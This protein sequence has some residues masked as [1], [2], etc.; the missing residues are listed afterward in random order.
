MIDYKQANPDHTLD[1]FNKAL[2]E[3]DPDTRRVCLRRLSESRY[4]T[5]S[6]CSLR[7]Q[8][9]FCSRRL[10]MLEAKNS[11]RPKQG[12]IQLP[13]AQPPRLFNENYEMYV[14]FPCI[15]TSSVKTTA[16]DIVMY[17]LAP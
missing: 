9:S 15:R 6:T 7:L 17:L 13:P 2:K 5:T 16:T 4:Y 1:Q 14:T 10:M 11:R 12:P 3:L 8:I